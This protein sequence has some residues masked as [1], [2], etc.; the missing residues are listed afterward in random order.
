MKVSEF[1][2]ALEAFKAEHGDLEVET[3]RFNAQK[4]C[5][6]DGPELAHRKVLRG[7]EHKPAFYR[8]YGEPPE[9][10]GDPVCEL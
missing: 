6:H 10:K 4:R 2:A 8:G 5:T 1:I 3:E 7:R 9:T